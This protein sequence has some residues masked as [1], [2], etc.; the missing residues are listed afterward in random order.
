MPIYYIFKGIFSDIVFD[1]KFQHP[2]LLMVFLWIFFQGVTFYDGQPCDF[3]LGFS[4]PLG[5]NKRSCQFLANQ[6]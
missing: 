4:L 6:F 5:E 3:D 2:H 1:K